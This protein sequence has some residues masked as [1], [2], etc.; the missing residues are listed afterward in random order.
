[1]AAPIETFAV[2]GLKRGL[3]INPAPLALFV[4]SLGAVNKIEAEMAKSV[5]AARSTLFRIISVAE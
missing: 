3:P 1:L 4:W 5:D 2:V